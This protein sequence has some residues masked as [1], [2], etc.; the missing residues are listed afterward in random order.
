MAGLA[1]YTV[2]IVFTVFFAGVVLQG[3]CNQPKAIVRHVCC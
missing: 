2:G 3:L 1:A